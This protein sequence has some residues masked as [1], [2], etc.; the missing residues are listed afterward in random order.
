M[1][2]DDI[3]KLVAALDEAIGP[4]TR[5]Y[6]LRRSQSYDWYPDEPAQEALNR[7]RKAWRQ[8]Q[9]ETTPE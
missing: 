2:A 9:D 8:Y 3:L 1:T 4:D 7:L 5:L 6:W